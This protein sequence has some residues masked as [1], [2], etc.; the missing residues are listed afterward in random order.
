MDDRTA[1]NPTGAG[2]TMLKVLAA[3]A[4][5]GVVV[6]ILFWGFAGRV[7]AYSALLGSLTSVLPNAFLALRLMVARDDAGAILRAAWLGELG[8]LGITVVMFLL[9]F[10]FVRPLQFLPLFAGFIAAQLMVFSG[11]L[12]KENGQDGT[13]QNGS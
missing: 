1:P 9:I 6:A 8:K 2:L 7:E 10:A 3:Q 13:E 12:M 5:V 4:G 11:L